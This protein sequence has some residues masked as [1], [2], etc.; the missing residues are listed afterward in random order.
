MRTNDAYGVFVCECVVDDDDD[1]GAAA[2]VVN[3][4]SDTGYGVS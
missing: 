3:V 4:Y 2:L 1:D